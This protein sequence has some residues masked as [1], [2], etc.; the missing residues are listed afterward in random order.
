VDQSSPNVFAERGRNHCRSH[1]FP[2]LDIFM[3]SGDIPNR[4][5]KFP[6]IALNF[7][8]FWLPS[9]FAGKAQ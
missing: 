9:F 3:R 7:V 6:E 2:N 1:V 5:L 8:R 4:S